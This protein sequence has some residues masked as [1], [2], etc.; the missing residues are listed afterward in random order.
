M[1]ASSRRLGSTRGDLF[2]LSMSHPNEELARTIRH[3][4]DLL[5]ERSINPTTR[6]SAL[7]LA[8]ALEVQLDRGEKATLQN[9]TQRFVAQVSAAARAGSISDGAAFDGFLE[10]PYSGI[11]NALAPKRVEYRRTGDR[12]T[13]TIELGTALEGRPG[14]AHGGAVAAVFDDVMGALQH[15]IGRNGYTRS[16]TVSYLAPFPT[17]TPVTIVAACVDHD[18]G[19]FTIEASAT[20]DDRTVATASAVFTEVSIEMWSGADRHETPSVIQDE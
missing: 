1:F 7:A 11:A 20:V 8:E 17:D 10:S 12:V 19:R 3:C 16:L 15:I 18:A 13:A 5:I 14:R 6:S 4:A 2:V 9:R